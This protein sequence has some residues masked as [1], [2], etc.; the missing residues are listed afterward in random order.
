LPDLL[1]R[2][3][4]KP[5]TPIIKSVLAELES[6]TGVTR[7]GLEDRFAAFLVEHRLPHPEFNAWLQIHGTWIE[8]DCVWHRQRLI[9]ELDSRTFHLTRAAFENDR[10]RDR[11][12]QAQGWRTVR[13]T[14]QQLQSDAQMLASDLRRLMTASPL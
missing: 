13:I 12:L 8:C 5:G 9:A 11:A 1:E 7:E 6:G 10:A 2:Y 4:G 3:P 14:W